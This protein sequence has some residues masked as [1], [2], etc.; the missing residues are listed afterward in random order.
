LLFS[1]P[2]IGAAQSIDGGRSELPGMKKDMFDQYQSNKNKPQQPK[3]K[4]PPPCPKSDFMSPFT[5]I[6]FTSSEMYVRL[7]GTEG[8]CTRL[9]TVGGFNFTNMMNFSRTCGPPGEWKRRVAENLSTVFFQGGSESWAKYDGEIVEVVTEEGTFEVEVTEAKYEVML[10]CWKRGCG[11][12][13]AKHPMMKVL[14]ITMGVIAIGGLGYDSAKAAYE[15]IVG[16]KPPKHVLSKAGHRMVKIKPSSKF[17]CDVCGSRGVAYQCSGG[18]E[19]HMTKKCYEEAKAK[20]KIAWKKWLEDHPE[21]KKSKKDDKDDDGEDEGEGEEVSKSEAESESKSGHTSG[22]EEGKSDK[23]GDV[24]DE[25]EGGA[26][27][28]DKKGEDDKKE[29]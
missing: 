14:F 13:Q 17:Y 2:A 29:E 7:N 23:S 8:K 20:V 3:S 21:D 10:E 1:Q 19:Y 28:T 11:C 6:T 24:A 22:Q 9:I 15:K 5:G 26:N 12:E 25:S 16:K 4:A 27:E 18:T